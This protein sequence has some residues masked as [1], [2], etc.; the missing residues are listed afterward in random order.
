MII[1]RLCAERLGL[2]RLIRS[3]LLFSVDIAVA[4]FNHQARLINANLDLPALTGLAQR[5]WIIAE[6]V[7]PSE[8]FSDLGEGLRNTHHAIGIEKA[9]T[10]R[11]GEVV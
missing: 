10:G 5:L 4:S 9:S 7:L 3:S 2:F 11:A 6:A 1:F 8:F